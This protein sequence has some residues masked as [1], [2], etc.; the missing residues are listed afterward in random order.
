MFNSLKLRALPYWAHTA[1]GAVNPD[2]AEKILKDLSEGGENLPE[3]W[4]NACSHC[5]QD[6][7][8][9][10]EADYDGRSIL[11]LESTRRTVQKRGL[12]PETIIDC[13]WWDHRNEKW[14]AIPFFPYNEGNPVRCTVSV[15]N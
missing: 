15:C 12:I 6:K 5:E 7:F 10:S 1:K 11:V 13:F 2:I 14:V 4:K 8:R 3:E 9:T